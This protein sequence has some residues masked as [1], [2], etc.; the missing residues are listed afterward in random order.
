M[1]KK[2][3][4]ITHTNVLDGK[5]LKV[6]VD[7]VVLP[8]GSR[9]RLEYVRHPGAIAVVPFLKHDAIILIRQWRPVIR[10]YIWEIPAGTLEKGESHDR[11]VQRELMEEISYAAR[12]IKKIGWIYTTP[13]FTTEKIWLY[14]ARD[15][16]SVQAAPEEDEVITRAVFT[17]RQ[18][19]RLY[20]SGDLVDCK[21]IAALAKCGVLSI[22]L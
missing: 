5:L 13:G 1:R 14:S 4:V 9:T 2:V 7:T 3:S 21:T 6:Y 8:N 11:C 17:V 20:A 15:L 16:V 18:I 19:R 22:R 12:H 10:R